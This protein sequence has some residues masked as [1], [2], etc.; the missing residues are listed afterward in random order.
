[1]TTAALSTPGSGPLALVAGGGSGGH[2][3]P[4]LAVAEVLA[5]RGWIVSWI[6]SEAGMERRLVARAG[7]EFLAAEARPFLGRGLL[8]R[9]YAGVRLLR[10]AWSLRGRL[11]ALGA[12]VLLGT[13]GYISAPAV[14]A[15]RSVG[16]PVLLFEPNAEAG[17]ANRVLSWISAEAAVAHPTTA[18]DFHCPAAVT[19]IPVRDAFFREDAVA[20]EAERDLRL[21]VVG[22]SQGA[23]QINE[24]V[25]EAVGPLAGRFDLRVTHQ[26]GP[27]DLDAV[28]A[29]WDRTPVEADV[30]AFLDDMPAAMAEHTL[31]VS[32]AGAITLAEIC[33]AGRPSVL[34]PLA[35]AAG[36]QASNARALV[37]AG[38]A[39]MLGPGD[40]RVE[41]MADALAALLGDAAERGRMS[42]A[43]RSLARRGAAEAIA[44]RLEDL[45]GAR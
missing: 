27:D 23:R 19:G 25:P 26:T 15:A 45:G 35:Q 4:G 33:A 34:V 11:R 1:M 40:V 5:K 30:R 3:F 44:D 10:S 22:G 43:A 13:G 28:R 29:A 17:L 37:D 12:R 6:G 24:L 9:I 41:E 20:A 21:L 39:R 38:A 36:H 16:L 31:L 2:V 32:R 42:V 18:G 14:L 7:L 8:A